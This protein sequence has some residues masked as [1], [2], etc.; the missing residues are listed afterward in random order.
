MLRDVQIRQDEIVSVA[1]GLL[2]A[3]ADLIDQEIID[4]QGLTLLPGVIAP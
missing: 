3:P 1:P 2:Q 4:A